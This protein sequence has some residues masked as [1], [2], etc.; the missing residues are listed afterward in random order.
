MRR[1]LVNNPYYFRAPV[2]LARLSV[3]FYTRFMPISQKNRSFRFLPLFSFIEWNEEHIKATITQE[4]SWR[5]PEKMTAGWRSD[6]KIHQ[7]RQY[8]YQEL[9]GY[10]KNNDLLSQLVRRGQI[11]REQALAR[12]NAENQVA[13]ALLDEI[14]SE[15]GFSF[16]QLE[17]SVNN[18]VRA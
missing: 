6:C 8:I 13:P 7:V 9:L 15:M 16:S 4:L 17:Y 1:I 3:E 11:T 12:L 2:G 14:L 10:T 18:A 5:V